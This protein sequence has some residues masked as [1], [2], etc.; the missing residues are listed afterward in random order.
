MLRL[1][2]GQVSLW[3]QVLPAEVRLLSTEL[4]AIDALLDDDRFLAPFVRRFGC[5]IGR[6]TVPI[7]TYL[8]LMYLKHRYGLGYETLVKEVSDSFSWRQFEFKLSR[9]PGWHQ[10]GARSAS[11]WGLIQDRE[12]CLVGGTAETTLRQ[13]LQLAV[14]GSRHRTGAAAAIGTRPATGSDAGRSAAPWR[15]LGAPGHMSH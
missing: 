8:R 5:R 2:D 9:A 13:D 15:L 3:E 4:S 12:A 6:P 14:D 11:S 7:E 1:H 10:P